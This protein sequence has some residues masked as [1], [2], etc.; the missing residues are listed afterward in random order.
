MRRI[1]MAVLMFIILLPIVLMGFI[2]GVVEVYFWA[3]YQWAHNFNE[4]MDDWMGE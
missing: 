1:I 4:R 3:G 2:W